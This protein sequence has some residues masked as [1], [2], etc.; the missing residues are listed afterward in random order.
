MSGVPGWPAAWRR[1]RREDV[2]SAI[3]LGGE[4]GE[5]MRVLLDSEIER[6][7]RLH[8]A[9]SLADQFDGFCGCFLIDITT[10]NL[11]TLIG[12]PE[13]HIPGDTP[14][15]PRD[16]GNLSFELTRH[17]PHLPAYL[18]RLSRLL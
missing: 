13:G 8:L 12:V 16:N 7:Q 6:V 18:V 15:G 9:P 3:C 10:D 11:G 5:P 17:A 2:D 4:F 1:S 14:S